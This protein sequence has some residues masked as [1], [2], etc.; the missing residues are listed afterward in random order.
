MPA[1]I[2]QI[3]AARGLVGWSQ[4]DLAAAAGLSRATINR[5]ETIAAS[6]ETIAAIQDALEKA[7]VIFVE[8]NGDGAGVRLK[9]RRAG[10]RSIPVEDLNAENDE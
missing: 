9:K 1:T 4:A 10:R 8:A 2:S 6:A 3:R 5:A 7:G